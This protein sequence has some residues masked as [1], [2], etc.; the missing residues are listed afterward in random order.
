[1]SNPVRDPIR[2]VVSRTMPE[3]QRRGAPVL[4]WLGACLLAPEPLLAS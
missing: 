3:G 4:R 2:G 1:V